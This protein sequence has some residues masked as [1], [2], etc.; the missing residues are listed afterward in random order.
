[1]GTKPADECTIGFLAERIH[2]RFL[3]D[4]GISELAGSIEL[5]KADKALLDIIKGCD[6][7][8][9]ILWA[10]I[11]RVASKLQK[12]VDD[13]LEFGV[14]E[15]ATALASK[16]KAPIGLD[17]GMQRVFYKVADRHPLLLTQSQIAGQIRSDRETVGIALQKLSHD[18]YCHQPRGKRGGW[19][20]TS[21][22]LQLAAQLNDRH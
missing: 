11:D 5:S 1:M 6:S 8:A 16:P 22:G 17:Q 14:S 9:E 20:L 21:K 10:Q 12:S 15:F 7:K 2:P 18:G 4:L 13:V 3:Q 19:G